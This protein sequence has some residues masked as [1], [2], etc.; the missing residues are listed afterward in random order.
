MINRR[1][2]LASA[3]VTGPLMSVAAQ[4]QTFPSKPITWIVPYPP[5]GP[6]DLMARTV[7]EIVG[8]RLGQP[9]LIDNRPGAGGQIAGIALLKADADGHVLM[10]GDTSTLGVN[11]AVYKTFGWEPVADVRGIAPMPVMPM[12]LLV[13]RNSPYN[14]LA[15]LVA[16]AKKRE[17]NYASQGAGSTGHLLG[18]MLKDAAGGRFNHIP[19]KGSAPAMNDLLGGQVDMLFDGVP[20]ALPQFRADKVKVL[21]IAGP[22]RITQLPEVP[23]TAELGYPGVAMSI[24]FGAVVR[25]GTPEA[26]VKTLNAEITQAMKQDKVTKRFGDLG[27]QPLTMG[28]REFGQF[29]QSEAQRWVAYVKDRNITIE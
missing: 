2:F 12:L 26:I 4:A 8:S 11:K 10:L 27:F 24:W 16:A 28:D 5:G 17:F 19:Y 14:S 18:E 6:G 20:P 3:L 1:T 13:P 15:E 21:A 22:S 7:G 9:V 25:K 23:T 29:I